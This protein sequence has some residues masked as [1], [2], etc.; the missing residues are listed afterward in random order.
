MHE[1]AGSLLNARLAR[2]VPGLTKALDACHDRTQTAGE[3]AGAAQSDRDRRGWS[4]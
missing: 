3:A 2:E 4:G 1:P